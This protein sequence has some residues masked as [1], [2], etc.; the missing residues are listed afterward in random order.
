MKLNTMFDICREY[1]EAGCSVQEQL[2]D[3]YD[4]NLDFPIGCEHEEGF[5][6]VILEQNSKALELGIEMLNTIARDLPSEESDLE[7][8]IH[9]F[10]QRIENAL[11]ED[12][13]DE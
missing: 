7:Y 10:T 3:V 11:E 4:A 12:E 13:N 2:M 1:N 6:E 8:E 9:T 5:L